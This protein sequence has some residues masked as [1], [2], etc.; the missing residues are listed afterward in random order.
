MTHHLPPVAILGA[1]SM[2]GAIAQGI[3]R[4]GE[5]TSVV[6]TNRTAAKARELDGLDAVTSIALADEP[7]ANTDAAASA[8]ILLIGVKPA[9]VPDV[10]REIAGALRPGTIVVSLAA[11]VTIETFEAIVGPGIPVIR[12]MPNTPA[13]VGKAVTGLA[14][15]STAT[16]EH[17]ALVR[18]LF[19]TCGVVIEVPE[20]QIDA[21]S[22]ISG[23]G[24]AYV[25]LLVEALTEAAR[26]KGFD[27][28]DA[29]LMAEQTFIGATAL[30]AA[31]GEDP[32]ELRRRVTSPKGTTERAI[33][34]LQTGNLDGLFSQATD[35]ALARA[36]ELATG[37]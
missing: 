16:P 32:A 25:F 7:S 22:T 27:E 12:S 4:S 11:G 29:R 10:L 37:V 33:G 34:V 14:A 30:L 24:P 28:A 15:G 35:A 36:R 8:D 31:S 23:S 26:G 6:V 18:R 1:G 19:E 3:A 17:V 2:G 9:L 21:L 13:V 5:A 20:T